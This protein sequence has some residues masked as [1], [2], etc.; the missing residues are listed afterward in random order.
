MSDRAVIVGRIFER[1]KIA[2]ETGCWE[3]QKGS[4]KAG[5]G[6]IAIKHG[7]QKLV[8]RLMF[9]KNMFAENMVTSD[10]LK[11]LV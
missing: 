5:Y 8:H 7:E 4:T 1:I 3:W 10:W 6:L 11:N 9:D 2:P